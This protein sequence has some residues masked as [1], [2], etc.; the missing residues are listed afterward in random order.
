MKP[1]LM[2]INKLLPPTMYIIY[3]GLSA[4]HEHFIYK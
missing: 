3:G 1:F 4:K 2:H